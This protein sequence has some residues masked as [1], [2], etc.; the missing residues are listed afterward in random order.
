MDR[1]HLLRAGMAGFS[2]ISLAALSAC[3]GPYTVSADVSSFGE[4][5]AGRKPGSFFIERLPSQK[6]QAAQSSLMGT[7]EASARAA[8]QKAGFTEAKDA[9][10]ADVLVNLGLRVSPQ[11]TA[12][13]DDPMWWRWRGDYRLWRYGRTP[14]MGRHHPSDMMDA[15]FDRAVAVLIRD[16]ATGEP[17]YEARASNEGMTYGDDK[18]YGA[19]FEASLA[20]FPAAKPDSHRVS[21][22]VQR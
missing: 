18:L 21:V 4:W 12:P 15:R 16:R 10:S 9:Q 6:H 7:V 19:L 20:D 2:L 22:M 5:P 17:L 13:W 3:S 11:D 1:R 8:L 14:F